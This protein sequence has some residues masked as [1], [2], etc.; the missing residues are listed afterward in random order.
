[1]NEERRNYSRV[2]FDAEISLI[3]GDKIYPAHLADISLNGALVGYAG[4]SPLPKGST[5]TLQISLNGAE[6]VLT[7]ES[8]VVF[9]GDEHIGLKFQ[10]IELESLTHLRR[11]LELNVGDPDK[12]KQELFFLA[13]HYEP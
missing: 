7:I 3:D 6:L 13:S 9:T 8:K 11:L 10:G 5:C 4:T 1:M 12:V 2:K